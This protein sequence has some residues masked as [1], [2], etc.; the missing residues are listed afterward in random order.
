MLT[1]EK[2][3]PHH[4][5]LKAGRIQTLADENIHTL[6]ETTIDFL[7]DHGYFQYE[8]SNFARI[9]KDGE[10]QVSKHNLKYWTRVPYMGLGPSAHSFI[11]PQRYWNVSSLS[12]YIKDI[13]NGELPVAGK[14]RLSLEQQRIEV[15]YLGLR[16][17]RGIDVAFYNKKFGVDFSDTL[18]KALCDL[19]EQNYIEI[20]NE[21]CRLTR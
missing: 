10:P 5:H 3:T 7:E 6:F 11:E 12:Q 9:G 18:K 14:E 15:I 17:T 16:M 21:H 8:T 4:S 1:Y 19:E 2:G 13:E 20:K